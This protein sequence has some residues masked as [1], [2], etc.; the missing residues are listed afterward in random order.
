MGRA[1]AGGL[2]ALMLLGRTAFT[3]DIRFAIIGDY[4][5]DNAPARNVANLVITNLEPAFI[6]TLGD[7]NYGTATDYDNAVGK[8]YARYIGNYSGAHGA[9]S[10]T[11]RFFPAI[12]NHDYYGDGYAA[13]TNY[14]TLPGNERYYDIRRGPVHIFI[15]NSDDH[16]PDGT[17]STSVQAMWLSNRLA[18][19][20]APWRLVVT[21]HAP[22]SSSGSDA[23]ARWPYAQ[24]GAD[25]VLAGHSH[26]YERIEHNGFPYIVNGVGGAAFA[27]I[28]SPMAGSRA[29]FDDK[30]GAML[31][32]ANEAQITLE[33]YSAP[34]AVLRDRFTLRRPKLHI[35]RN[36]TM[37]EV[38]WN[39]NSTPFDLESF[40]ITNWVEIASPA[41]IRGTNNVVTLP[42]NPGREVFRLRRR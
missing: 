2:I 38:A 41:T 26:N 30:Y 40:R 22:Y 7:N 11:N 27:P 16:E 29:H 23:S 18:A 3:A 32:I 20:D 34:D 36:M 21:H 10:P 15:L 35:T 6:V 37:V 13:Y 25:M 8:Y 1:F 42:L 31:A 5:T 17:S 19:S 24:W 28:D 14:F 4:G 9:G 33:F 12:G 39:T